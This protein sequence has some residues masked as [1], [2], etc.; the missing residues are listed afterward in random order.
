MLRRRGYRI[1]PH[2]D[3]NWSF[4]T[5]ILYLAR[6]GD[7]DAWGTQIFAVDGDEEAKNA[8]PYWIDDA[9]C[10]PVEVARFLPNRLLV[11]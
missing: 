5:C 8:G 11:F 3:P 9:R 10:R 7:S 6:S 2:R 4:I 1:K